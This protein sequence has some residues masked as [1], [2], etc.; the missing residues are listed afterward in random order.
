[1]SGSEDQILDEFARLRPAEVLVPE[2]PTGE[3]HSVA[4]KLEQRGSTP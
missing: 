4:A 2:L 3:P 1:M